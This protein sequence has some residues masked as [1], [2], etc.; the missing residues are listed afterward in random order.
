MMRGSAQVSDHK[1]PVPS[2]RRTLLISSSLTPYNGERSRYDEVA[3]MRLLR[4]VLDVDVRNSVW[5]MRVANPKKSDESP[6]G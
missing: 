1:R 4:S 2:P 6:D 3:F 5:V